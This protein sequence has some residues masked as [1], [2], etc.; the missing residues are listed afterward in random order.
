MWLREPLPIEVSRVA[1]VPI[2]GQFWDDVANAPM[3]IS[4]YSFSGSV[5]RA[6]GEPSIYNFPVTVSSAAAGMVDF[7]IDG[8]ALAGQA[9]SKETVNLSYQIKANDGQGNSV[10][11]VRGPL[12]LTPGI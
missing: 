3:D 7:K 4:G 6:D 12:I 9:G 8:S 5:A 1:S 2:G 11:A 10:I